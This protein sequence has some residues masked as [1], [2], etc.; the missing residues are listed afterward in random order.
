MA[1][2]LIGGVFVAAFSTVLVLPASADERKFAYSQEAKTL[3]SGSFEFEQWATVAARKDSGTF[4]E[5]HFREEFEYG[6]TDRFT[7]AAYLNWEAKTIHDVPGLAEEK[8][9]KFAG[10]S[11][12]GKYKFTDASADPLGTL[13][14]AEFSAEQDEYEIELK[15]VAS[16][17]WGNWTFAYNFIVETDWVG[18]LD[19]VTGRR[20]WEHAIL[21][22][23]TAGVSYGLLPILAVGIEGMARTPFDN[24]LDRG[25][26]AYFVG[27][28]V[29]VAAGPLWGTLTFLRQV[30][31]QGHNRLNLDGFEKYEIRLIVG[32]SF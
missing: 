27:P 32:I 16:K 19:P 3:A 12:E 13:L 14:Y 6:V 26:T 20:A 18:Q 8:D 7:A 9:A 2:I 31:P 11:L 21:M 28:N 5:W 23:N 15:G 29:H 10:I 4:R 22:E 1:R 30:D 25:Q 24:N 17:S